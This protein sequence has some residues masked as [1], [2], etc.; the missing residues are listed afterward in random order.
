MRLLCPTHPISLE[1]Q[2]DALVAMPGFFTWVH[3]GFELGFLRMWS[4][5]FSCSQFPYSLISLLGICN[6]LSFYLLLVP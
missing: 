4:K 2:V 3:R 5:C 6:W 1:L